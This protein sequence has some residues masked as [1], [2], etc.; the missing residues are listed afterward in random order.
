MKSRFLQGVH[1][2]I[3]AHCGIGEES[4]DTELAHGRKRASRCGLDGIV[5]A[6]PQA[7]VGGSF[8]TRQLLM[9]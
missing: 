5:L 6:P 2:V 7:D 4:I 8:Y 1:E 3:S 9:E